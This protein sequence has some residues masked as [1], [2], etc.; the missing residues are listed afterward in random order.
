MT[1]DAAN[2]TAAFTAGKKLMAMLLKLE[3][4]EGSTGIIAQSNKIW[5][6]F[7]F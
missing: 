5:Q 3:E 6:F 7:F 4:T 2:I 1:A